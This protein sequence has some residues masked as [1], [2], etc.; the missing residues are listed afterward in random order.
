M[1]KLWQ[2]NWQLNELVESFETKND[3]QL[4][5]LL[6]E[7]DVYGCLAHAKGLHRI[8]LL[9]KEE[10]TQL[11][12]GLLEIL[13]LYHEGNFVVQLG[14][15]DVHSKIE[16]Y[17]T[18]KY[19]EVGKKIHTGRSRND[20]VLTAIRLYT[21]DNVLGIWFQLL[22]LI[23]SF[24][25]FSQQY[26]KMIMP[27]YTHMQKAMPSSVGMWSAAFAESL[28]DDLKLLK[29]AFELND[30]SPLG[31]GAGYGVPLPLPRHYTAELLGFNKVQNNP[32]ACQNSRGKIE[33]AVLAALVAIYQDISRFASDVLLF[34]T[35]E[36]NFFEVS[37]ELCT[38]SSIMP[39]KKNIDIA[40]LLRSKVHVFLGNYV[41]VVS[42]SSN[43]VSGY[44]RDLQDSKK[45]FFES[46]QLAAEGLAVANLLITNIKPNN[47]A[48]AKAL[49][50]ELFATHATLQMVKNGSAF[51]EAYQLIGN[52]LNT[53]K[54]EEFT[55]LQDEDNS[56]GSLGKLG[57]E[58]T[59]KILEKEK[60][61]FISIS[62]NYKKTLEMLF[63]KGE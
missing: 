33:A 30:Q 51:R 35:S 57:L 37:A 52:D 54:K 22:E 47:D 60:D 2:K 34:T 63:Q 39:Q 14:D 32:I 4:D 49:T 26:E 11:Q 5:T 62:N 20:Q 29:T 9:T 7:A 43:L 24:I 15:E 27:G 55:L 23:E 25:T 8:Q 12:Q 50:S 13:D 61:T 19:G 40:E 56:E 36:F 16:A 31:S 28:L 42:L 53:V 6:V 46:M 38:G 59:S 18:D 41:Q 1:K 48:I 58:N 3:I 44:N 45:P 17:L 10:V 21:K